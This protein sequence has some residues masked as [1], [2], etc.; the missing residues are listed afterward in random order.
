MLASLTSYMASD[1]FAP[2]VSVTL[3]QLRSLFFD[4]AVM[5]RIGA[6]AVADSEAEGG[7]AGNAIDGNPET[8][9]A[10]PRGADPPDWPHTLSVSL[11]REVT[12]TGL[13]L[14][15]PQRD[16]KRVGEIADYVV[17]TSQ[18]GTTWA[19]AARGRLKST[20]RTQTVAFSSAVPMRHLRLI[21]LSN[22]D[23]SRVATL[24]EMTLLLATSDPASESSITE[25]G[26][27]VLG[28][29][30]ELETSPTTP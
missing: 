14:L 10:T 26:E 7:G 11:D 21:A 22:H 18:D 9:W 13:A 28:Q 27:R 16:R 30:D 24:A 6:R 17:E 4:A 8:A 29:E 3:E 19:E 20:Y 1:R 5:K 25:E 2:S 23:D 12:A 15:A